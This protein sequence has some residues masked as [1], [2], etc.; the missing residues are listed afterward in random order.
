M[1]EEMVA[2][3]DLKITNQKCEM[4]E[5]GAYLPGEQCLTYLLILTRQCHLYIT[6]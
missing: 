2:K 5:E 4:I 6:F 3:V 1:N